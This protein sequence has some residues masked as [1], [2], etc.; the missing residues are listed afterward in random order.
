MNE[1]ELNKKITAYILHGD[2]SYLI[3]YLKNKQ[4]PNQA[5]LKKIEDWYLAFSIKPA[6]AVLLPPTKEIKSYQGF[7]RKRFEASPQAL[8]L[9]DDLIQSLR[10]RSS[11]SSS[12]VHL[13]EAQVLEMLQT[14][15]NYRQA[16]DEQYHALKYFDKHGSFPPI[17]L[18]PE[19]SS[20]PTAELIKK[21]NNNRVYISRA[22]KRHLSDEKLAR[23]RQAQDEISYILNQ[24][25]HQD[26]A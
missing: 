26:H 4:V 20:L 8:A 15:K 9:F 16:I 12:L 24:R 23:L 11:C 17:L 25:N 6:T 18:Q 10:K 5:M 22:K 3:N 2:N 13:S 7:T 1:A 21:M 19:L 14:I